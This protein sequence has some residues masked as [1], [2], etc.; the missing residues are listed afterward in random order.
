[1]DKLYTDEELAN[2]LMKLRNTYYGVQEFTPEQHENIVSTFG[3]LL[4]VAT[5][6]FQ[7]MMVIT[8]CKKVFGWEGHNLC[9]LFDQEVIL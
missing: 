6:E 7:Q 3:L 9:C 2:V 4:T 1:M 8:C 5:T